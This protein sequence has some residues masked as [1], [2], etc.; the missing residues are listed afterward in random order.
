MSEREKRQ[1]AEYAARAAKQGQQATKNVGR[2]AREAAKHSVD[3]TADTAADTVKTARKIVPIAA[4]RVGDAAERV[5]EVLEETADKTEQVVKETVLPKIPEAYEA[6]RH[7]RQL[8]AD[9]AESVA[10]EAS[11]QAKRISPRVLAAMS[12]DMGT[13][14]FALTVAIYS[15]VIA[16]NKFA[17]AF[18]R[19]DQV[20]R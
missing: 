5:N 16:Y 10:G 15:S 2:A 8:G 19:H 9:T 3:V 1:A 12:G 20:I 6:S 4:E 13:G 11:R 17:A 7:V 18:A 14:F